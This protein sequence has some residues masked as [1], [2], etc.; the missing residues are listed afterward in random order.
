MAKMNVFVTTKSCVDAN[1]GELM[2]TEEVMQTS[3]TKAVKINFVQL[4]DSIEYLDGLSG[5]EIKVLFFL[6]GKAEMN[7]AQVDISTALR[8][9]ISERFKIKKGSVRNMI[10]KL[11][12]L[13][14]IKPLKN[15]KYMLN[16]FVV[17]KGNSN[18]VVKVRE[19][20]VNERK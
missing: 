17:F 13:G 10:L 16:P 9:E 6:A 18:N 15:Q 19:L 8:L 11:I 2:F 14:L 12:G 3:L 4:Y 20:F 5:T 7:T 1:T